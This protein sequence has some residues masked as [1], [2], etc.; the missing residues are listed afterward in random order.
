VPNLDARIAGTSASGAKLALRGVKASHDIVPGV[1][2][3]A[4]PEDEGPAAGEAIP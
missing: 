3:G 1:S 2:E 4:P